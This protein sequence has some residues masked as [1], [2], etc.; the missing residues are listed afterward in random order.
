MFL[1]FYAEWYFSCLFI[2]FFFF[3]CRAFSLCYQDTASFI[4]YSIFY[5]LL[6]GW[7]FSIYFLLKWACH[8]FLVYLHSIQEKIIQVEV[9]CNVIRS[10]LTNYEEF[11][12]YA[13]N[14]L[15]LMIRHNSGS[16]HCFSVSWQNNFFL[17]SVI[18]LCTLTIVS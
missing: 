18:Y 15:S 1:L 13:G 14:C 7:I 8:I 3:F 4:V 2:F 6:K 10:P 11:W 12:R 9:C 17:L 16:L 5:C